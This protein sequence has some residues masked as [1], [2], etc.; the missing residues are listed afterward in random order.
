MVYQDMFIIKSLQA[1]KKTCFQESV[2]R[3]CRCIPNR[4]TQ[5]A[6]VFK[7]LRETLNISEGC[8]SYDQSNTLKHSL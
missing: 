2:M 3:D 1:C 8:V 7:E 5:D 4:V 6:V